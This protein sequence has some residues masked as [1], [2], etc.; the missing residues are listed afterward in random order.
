[1]R[2]MLDRLLDEIS[3]WQHLGDDLVLSALAVLVLWALRTLAVKAV[4]ARSSDPATRYRW[5][6]TTAYLAVGLG[7]VLLGAIWIERFRSLATFLGLLTAG[8]AIALRD[9]VA[10]FAGWLF[11]LVRRPFE[12]GDR[13]QIGE[14]AGDVIDLR[15]FKFTLM[16]IGNWVD[17]DQSTGRVV[18]VPNHL[19]LT[20]SVINFTGGFRFIW[21]ELPVLV[22]FESDWKLAKRLLQEIADRHAGSAAE[23]ARE[24]L[25]KAS[26]RFML[27]YSQ[28][29]PIVYTKVV[30]SGVLLTIRHLCPPRQRRGLSEAIWEE[31]LEQFA[32]HDAIDFAYPTQRFFTNYREG[33]PPLRAA[34]ETLAVDAPEPAPAGRRA[35][36]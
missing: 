36:R 23:E 11:I 7:V 33:K 1:M 2:Q 32:A 22:T 29:T 10:S 34:E 25:R 18:H 31:I 13:I 20:D 12:V 16:E 9:L 27:Y 4:W 30:E 8:L 28:L 21:N 5:K 6:K 17:A 26:R 19:V 24:S 3:R 15:I 14:H 35:D